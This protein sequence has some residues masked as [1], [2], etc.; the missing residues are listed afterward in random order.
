MAILAIDAGTTGVTAM[1]VSLEGKVLSR[2]YQEFEQHFP[3]PGWVEHQPEQIWQATL[4]AVRE[5]LG[6]ASESPTC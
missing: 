3:Q 4:A 1:V 6:T 2:G 5:A